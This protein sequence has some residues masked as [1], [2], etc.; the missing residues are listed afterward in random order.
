MS[1]GSNAKKMLSITFHKQKTKKQ[2]NDQNS[3][4]TTKNYRKTKHYLYKTS[5]S[6]L[7]KASY[8]T[9]GNGFPGKVCRRKFSNHFIQCHNRKRK[10]FW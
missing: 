2:I 3:Y 5:Y 8:T 10:L 1:H 6:R 4:L 7:F 9:D